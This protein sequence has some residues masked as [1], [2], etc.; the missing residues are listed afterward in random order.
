MQLQVQSKFENFS[1]RSEFELLTFSILFADLSRVL[2]E[3]CKQQKW[4]VPELR[5]SLRGESSSRIDQ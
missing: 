3:L 5:P 1:L 4:Q 2:L